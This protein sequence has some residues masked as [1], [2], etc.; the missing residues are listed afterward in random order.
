MFIFDTWPN[1]LLDDKKVGEK[2]VK[3]YEKGG[4]LVKSV[5]VSPPL[6]SEK[7]NFDD[8]VGTLEL[9]VSDAV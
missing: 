4:K 1:E 6:L 9:H 5:C 7:R 3:V 2:I 8:Y